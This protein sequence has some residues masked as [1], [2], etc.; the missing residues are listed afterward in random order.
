MQIRTSG[1]VGLLVVVSFAL[2][3][4]ELP[5]E[6][7]WSLGAFSLASGV[8]AL[9]LMGT[10]GVLGGRWKAVE[11]VFG[12]LDRVYLT[13]KWLGIGALLFASFHFA[14]KAD[15]EGWETASILSLPPFYTR[16]V[17]QLSF[18]ALMFIVVTALDRKIPY[19]AWR[20]WHKTSGPLF[21]IVILHWLSFKSP[22][23]L[24]SPAGAWLAT[25][26]SLGVAAA[27]YKLVL[28]RWVSRHAEYRIESIDR[29]DGAVHLELSPVDR[30]IA[31]EPGQ[32]AFLRMKEDGLREPHPFTI[33]SGD[34]TGG[35]VHFVIRSLGD[36][37]QRLVA[38]STVGM[39]ADV[40]LPFGRFERPEAPKCEIW[41]GGGVGISPFIAWM[42]DRAAVGLAN[43]SLFYFYT[44]DRVFPSVDVLTQMAT[45]RGVEFIPCSSGPSNPEFETRFRALVERAGPANVHVRFCGPKGLLAVIRRKMREAG[46]PESNLRFEY[47]EFR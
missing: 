16:L 45:E 36:Y 30:P 41:I 11:S 17:R 5:R 43:V 35:R 14:F 34:S 7:W 6:T 33:A 20:L 32:F 42:T 15:V 22:I 18:L 28:Y 40:Y 25:I 46:V 29:G 47:F 13:H 26:S 8:A 23:A 3:A 27:F 44:P 4:A 24:E 38:S 19:S 21:G 1:A 39:H 12:G 37:T 31:F 2:V 9:A 10:A